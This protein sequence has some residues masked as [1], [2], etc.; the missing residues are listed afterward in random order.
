MIERQ[1]PDIQALFADGREID[2]AL[3]EAVRGA[4]VMHKRMGYPVVAWRD[5]RVV[6]IPPEQI[7]VDESPP[8]TPLSEP[9]EQ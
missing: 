9:T 6:W 2:A 8:I 7:E 1:S 5:G 4:L 3:T